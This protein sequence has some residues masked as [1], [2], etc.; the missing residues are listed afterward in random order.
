VIARAGASTIADADR[1]RTAA[2]LIPLPSATRPPDGERARDGGERRRAY[3]RASASRRRTR[4]ADAETG[5]EPDALTFAATKA[6]GVGRPN[7][8]RDLADLVER[9][10]NGQPLHPA[11]VGFAGASPAADG[12]RAEGAY[13]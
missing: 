10:A 1:I 9:V 3:D 13:A 7:A 8:A 6:R 12:L 2:I 11:E 5:L 4:Q